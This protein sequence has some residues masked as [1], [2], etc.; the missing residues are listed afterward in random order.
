MSY[1]VNCGVELEKGRKEC[2]LCNTPVINP[3]ELESKAAR[4]AFPKEKGQVELVKRKD[5]G[6]LISIVAVATSVTCGVLNLLV[7]DSSRWSLAII[8]ACALLWV[9]LIPAVIYTKLPVY[10][11]LLLDGIMVA[12]Y[13]YML[14]L[15]TKSDHWF[16]GLALPITGLFTLLAEL[17]TLC[18]RCLPKS[19]LT[20]ALYSFTGLGLL[21][22]G[23]EM[24]I[25]RYLRGAVSLTWSA[26][27][28]TVCII[29]DVT[30]ITLLSKKRFRNAVRR[31]LHF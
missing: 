14:T 30:I 22:C 16:W 17:F 1:C 13:L 7:Y 11:C 9:M 28:L 24:L 21:C 5:M 2:P 6:V 26:V 23:L 12:I 29:I 18:I 3:K 8:G 20:T 15:V 27:V 4:P 19:F 10:V 25:D 31:R